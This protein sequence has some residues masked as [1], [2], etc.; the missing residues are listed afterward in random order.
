MRISDSGRDKMDFEKTN[1]NAVKA[2]EKLKETMNYTQLLNEGK[3]DENKEITDALKK[4]AEE[5]AISKDAW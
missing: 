1:L 4:S 2:R 5:T 3:P